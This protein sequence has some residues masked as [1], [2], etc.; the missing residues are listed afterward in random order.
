V[1]ESHSK[2]LHNLCCSSSIGT[3]KA[4]V[5]KKVGWAGHVVCI[6][7]RNAFGILVLKTEETLGRPGV[8]T[9]IILK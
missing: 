5:L 1:R 2:D 7:G 8:G 6:G 9:R 3:V 4:V